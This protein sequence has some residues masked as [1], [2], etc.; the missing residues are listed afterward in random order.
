MSSIRHFA[1]A[2]VAWLGWTVAAHG[3]PDPNA[4][5]ILAT[6]FEADAASQIALARAAPDGQVHVEIDGALVTY[7][8]ALI[9]ADAAGFFIQGSRPGPALFIRVDPATLSPAPSPGDTVNLTVTGMDTVLGRR[10]ATGVAGFAGTSAGF[11]LDVLTQDVSAAADLTSAID[12]YDSEL[13]SASAVIAGPWLPAGDAFL[14]AP[15]DTAAIAGDPDL[16][17]RLPQALAQD[18]ALGPDCAIVVQRVP[19][20]RS[21]S[22]AQVTPTRA[23]EFSVADCAAFGLIRAVAT[24]PTT[25]RLEFNRVLDGATVQATAFALSDGLVAVAAQAQSRIAIVTTSVQ[26]PG[27]QYVVAVAPSIRDVNGNSIAGANI[28]QFLG[29]SP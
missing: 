10:E 5:L 17:L 6:G 8:R 28:A 15:I 4:G 20:L 22:Q 9:G 16:V 29:Y 7:T 2:V 12:S 24:S 27:H 19:L 13:V 21:G 23:S 18:L 14:L 1:C 26:V 25:L 3:Q 11:P